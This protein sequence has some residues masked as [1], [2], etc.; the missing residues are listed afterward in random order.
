MGK[1]GQEKVSL[2]TQAD[3]GENSETARCGVV[4]TPGYF[5]KQPVPLHLLCA[6][7]GSDYFKALFRLPHISVM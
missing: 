4:G 3:G 2:A 1:G 6:R 7:H 5:P